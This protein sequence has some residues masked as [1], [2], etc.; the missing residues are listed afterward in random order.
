[1]SSSRQEYIEA[2]SELAKV[3]M[4]R[5]GIPASVTLAQAIIESAN[6][7]STLSNQ[8]N[9]HFGIKG[10]FHGNYVLADDDKPNEHFKKYDNVGQSFED[11]SKVLMNDRYSKL[12]KNL[13]PDDY[14]GWA[15]AIKKGGYATD[16][17]YVKTIVGV[18]EGCNLQKYDQMVMQEMKSKGNSFGIDNNPLDVSTSLKDSSEKRAESYID[19]EGKKYSF[20]LKRNEFMLV[21]SPFG[22]RRD[23]MDH[24]KQ[25]MHKGID[26]QTKHEA[27]LATEDKGI[28]IK[29]SQ[30]TNTGGGRTV[31]IEYNRNDGSK[32][33]CTY[34]HLDSI[35]VKVGDTV[36]AGQKLGTSGNTGT[37][38]TGEHLHF[39]VKVVSTD[40]ASRDLD[41]AA[42]LAD[43][44][45][46]GNIQLQALHNGNDIISQYKVEDISNR[47][48]EDKGI[49]SN[50]SP[51][52]WMKKILSSED[53]GCSPA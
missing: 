12:T 27:V 3:Q 35:A 28:V 6:G 53:S 42:Y 44:A 30:N 38:T 47:K 20:P 32:Y 13:A 18:I 34:M 49:D 39:G 21:T 15:T 37:R 36:N 46:K 1:M 22:L 25:Q 52:E 43:I 24:S 8:A 2:Y 11:H 50:L 48:K 14:R 19:T 26:I 16:S 31:T 17:N 10:D 23:P 40:G 29:A 41:P 51:D 33:Q 5:Y 4:R 9:N 7:K 45:Q